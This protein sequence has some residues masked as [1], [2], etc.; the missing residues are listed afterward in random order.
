VGDEHEDVAA[1]FSH[2]TDAEWSFL[3]FQLHRH[4]RIKARPLIPTFGEVDELINDET[5][6]YKTLVINHNDHGDIFYHC[7]ARPDGTNGDSWFYNHAVSIKDVIDQLIA[8][9]EIQ[10]YVSKTL[11]S[12][13]NYVIKHEK[14]NDEEWEPDPED[15]DDDEWEPDPEDSDD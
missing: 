10:K 11:V 1:E 2:P 9:K 5:R 13:T 6:V 8:T 14:Q 15:S 7:V 4:L 3:T 12:A